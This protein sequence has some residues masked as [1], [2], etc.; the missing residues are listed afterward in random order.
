MGKNRYKGLN[1][2][3]VASRIDTDGLLQTKYKLVS[4]TENELFTKFTVNVL[5]DTDED[6]VS[7][8]PYF[9]HPLEYPQYTY[10][11]GGYTPLASYNPLQQLDF[12]HIQQSNHPIHT[13]PFRSIFGPKDF[14]YP[15]MLG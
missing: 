4:R 15:N 14:P 13:T 7:K 3:I 10:A 1:K 11:F 12:L 9:K 6:Q 2:K 5:Y 8:E